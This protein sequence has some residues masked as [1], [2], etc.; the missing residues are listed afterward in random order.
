MGTTLRRNAKVFFV[1]FLIVMFM[2]GCDVYA[3]KRPS[4][5]PNSVWICE[6]ENMAIIVVE[7]GT[8][9]LSFGSSIISKTDEPKY[10]VKFDYGDCIYIVSSATDEKVMTGN[11]SFSSQKMVVTIGT[12]DLFGGKYNLKKLTFRK[13]QI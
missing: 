11:C 9:Y 3:G 13:R 5:Y 7:D 6:E 4:A 2:Y 12:D 1:L 10:L 8:A